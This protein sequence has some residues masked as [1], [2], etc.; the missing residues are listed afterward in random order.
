M[1]RIQ[2]NDHRIGTYEINEISLPC[3]DDK[4]YFQKNGCVGLALGY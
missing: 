4:I 2:S 1:N 3:L